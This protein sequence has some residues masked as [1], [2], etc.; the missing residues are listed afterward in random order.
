M[1]SKFSPKLMS[2][3]HNPE[4]IEILMQLIVEKDDCSWA[5]FQHKS[6]KG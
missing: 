4:Q 3:Y 6:N 1:S 2:A 5:M